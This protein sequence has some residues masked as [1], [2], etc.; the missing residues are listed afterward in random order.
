MQ[1]AQRKIW[2]LRARLALEG[3]ALTLF[4]LTLVSDPYNPSPVVTFALPAMLLLVSL[5][6]WYF[7]REWPQ[8]QQETE[9]AGAMPFVARGVVWLVLGVVILAVWITFSGPI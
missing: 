1:R 7:R 4:V 8:M 2:A 6:L 5:H 9:G 3:I